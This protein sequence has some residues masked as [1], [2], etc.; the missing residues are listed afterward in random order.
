LAQFPGY[1]GKLFIAK[2]KINFAYK[3]LRGHHVGVD[4]IAVGFD[5]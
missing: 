1:R 4:I 3:I 2:K 5:R